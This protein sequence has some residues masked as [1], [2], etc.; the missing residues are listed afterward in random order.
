MRELLYAQRVFQ[1]FVLTTVKLVL[2]IVSGCIIVLYLAFKD[3]RTPFGLL[4]VLYN[5]AIIFQCLS[6]VALLFTNLYVRTNSPL[7]LYTIQFIFMQG[8]GSY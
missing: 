8:I 1:F 7:T 6:A 5:G 4:M 3:M 2:T